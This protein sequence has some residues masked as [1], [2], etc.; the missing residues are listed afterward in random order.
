MKIDKTLLFVKISTKLR[1]LLMKFLKNWYGIFGKI[2]FEKF[3]NKIGLKVSR[4]KLF[5]V[6]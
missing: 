5:C 1:K 2:L 3:S 6:G 4:A